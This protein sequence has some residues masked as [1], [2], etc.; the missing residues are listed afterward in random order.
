MITG[1]TC[2]RCSNRFY[3][4]PKEVEFISSTN[5]SSTTSSS[6][7]CPECA[8]KFEREGYKRDFIGILCP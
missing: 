7:V 6:P 2:K 8:P 4:E 5:P 3:M 1:W